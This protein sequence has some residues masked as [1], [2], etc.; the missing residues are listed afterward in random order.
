MVLHVREGPGDNRPMDSP[1]VKLVSSVAPLVLV[2]VALFALWQ[3]ISQDQSSWSGAGFGMFATVDG[4][5]TRQVRGHVEA[6][7][8]EV[9][10][11]AAL[12][13]AAFEVRVLPTNTR[14]NRLGEL[15]RADAGIRS[16]DVLVV[17][18]WR[19]DFNSDTGVLSR[20]V[21]NQVRVEP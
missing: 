18:V 11:P 6:T 15:W 12:E 13:Q 8:R 14:L 17:E 10:L 7:G 20:S 16:A 3:T 19:L 9:A 4:E 5:A 21:L 2:V 1:R